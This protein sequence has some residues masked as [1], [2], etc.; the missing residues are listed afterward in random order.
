MEKNPRPAGSAGHGVGALAASLCRCRHLIAL[1][2][3][4]E[5]AAAL[6]L[7][8]QAVQARPVDGPLGTQQGMNSVSC[9]LRCRLPK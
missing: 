5:L 2:Q 3:L 7:A 9:F 4:A 8:E 1:Q 6:Q